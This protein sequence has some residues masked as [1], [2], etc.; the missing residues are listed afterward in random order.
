MIQL[1]RVVSVVSAGLFTISCGALLAP[2][3]NDDVAPSATALGNE[4]TLDK[5]MEHGCSY[6]CVQFDYGV[7]DDGDGAL[8]GLEIDGTIHVCLEES[9]DPVE[10]DCNSCTV[11]ET[12]C[13]EMTLNCDDGTTM[14]WAISPDPRTGPTTC[15]YNGAGLAVEECQ[16]GEWVA[17][18]CDCTEAGTADRVQA[19]LYDMGNPTTIEGVPNEGFAT[20]GNR[21][22]AIFPG[23]N[24]SGQNAQ[25]LTI[26]NL[27]TMETVINSATA[28][29]DVQDY[30]NNIQVFEV[31]VFFSSVDTGLLL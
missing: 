7:D 15:G 14:S 17:T 25:L 30:P 1:L 24:N 29:A 23:T 18:G 5:C 13:D 27:D 31:K 10:P 20:F 16:E 22:Y 19:C 9:V 11:T 26:V 3:P 2:G 4:I 21:L 8:V 12:A 28:G 6:G